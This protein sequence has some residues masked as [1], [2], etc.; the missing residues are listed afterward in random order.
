MN[1]SPT[2]DMKSNFVFHRCYD[3]AMAQKFH[4]FA[5][6]SMMAHTVTMSVCSALGELLSQIPGTGHPLEVELVPQDRQSKN[7]SVFALQLSESH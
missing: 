6:F 4:V 3:T 5:R 7:T 2:H 1:R